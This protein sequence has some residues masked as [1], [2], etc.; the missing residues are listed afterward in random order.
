MDVS[1]IPHLGYI[2]RWL[3][4]R[5][6]EL[7]L[8]QGNPAITL[9]DQDGRGC[10]AVIINKN[11][12]RLGLMDEKLETY[13]ALVVSWDG[14]KTRFYGRQEKNFIELSL[15]KDPKIQVFAD[16]KVEILNGL[17]IAEERSMPSDDQSNI[18]S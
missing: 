1:T 2:L 7:I 13:S 10:G 15:D 9:Q 12:I 16:N 8:I 18:R 4:A 5:D 11:G 3:D 14:H 6:I 17:S